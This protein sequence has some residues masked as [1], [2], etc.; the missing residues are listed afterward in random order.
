VNDNFSHQLK[1]KTSLSK[2]YLA[3]FSAP[4]MLL[5]P[6]DT[7]AADVIFDGDTQVTQSLVY[8]DDVYVGR[9]Q[10]GNL[11][12]NNGKITAYNVNIGR[13]YNGQIFN[14]TVTVSGPDAELNALNDQFVLHGSMDLG[15]GTLRVENGA[16][17]SAKEIVVG[18]TRGY[19][20]HLIATGA[21][22]RVTSNYLSV[23]TAAGSRSTVSI[24]DGALLTTNLRIGDGYD[25]DETDKLNPKATVTGE[26][27]RWNVTQL[28]TLNGDL[29][30]L[31]GGAVNVGSIEVEGVPGTRKTAELYVAGNNSRFTSGGNILVGDYGNGVVSAVDGAVISAGSNA[32]VLGDTGS[33][34]NRGA[35]VIGSRGNRY[36]HRPY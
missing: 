36:R 27:S 12:I 21:N 5:M 33:G 17:A 14:S 29:D 24:E 4:L 32:I 22:S 35:L 15:L 18:T 28:L 11:L 30:V 9:T 3:L 16:L 31:N 7:R 2:L 34:S 20:S 25:P 19:D 10:S 8:T 1:V 13:L 26:N 6:E 23:G